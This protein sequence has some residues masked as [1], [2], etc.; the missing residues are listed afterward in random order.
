MEGTYIIPAQTHIGH[1]HLKVSDLKRSMEFYCGLLGFELT[2]GQGF[3]TFGSRAIHKRAGGS[4][5]A[6]RLAQ[7]SGVTSTRLA[8]GMSGASDAIGQRPHH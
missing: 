3:Y 5:P 6:E 1:V 8:R 4:D 2:T 7:K